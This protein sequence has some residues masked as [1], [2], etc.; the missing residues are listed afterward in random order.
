VRQVG[1]T[2]HS[3]DDSVSIAPM[4]ERVHRFN[5]EGRSI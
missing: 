4:E 2:S 3:V 5:A 1:T